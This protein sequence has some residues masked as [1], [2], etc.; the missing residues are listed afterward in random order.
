LPAELEEFVLRVRKRTHQPLC[1][2]FGIASAEQASRVAK[3]ADGII[4]GS[5]IIQ[6]IKEPSLVPLEQFIKE[7]RAV[8]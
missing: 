4:V 8:I 6:L 5:R 3:I 1:V 2:G 7:L